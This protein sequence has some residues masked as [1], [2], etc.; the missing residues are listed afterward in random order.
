MCTAHTFAPLA[1]RYDPAE[2]HQ[3]HYC[4]VCSFTIVVTPERY[5]PAPTFSVLTKLT[6]EER[7]TLEGRPLILKLTPEAQRSKDYKASKLDKVL[8]KAPAYSI[9]AV[10]A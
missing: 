3:K 8:D 9:R 5:R 4:V 6:R 2:R 10:A 1:N 7:E